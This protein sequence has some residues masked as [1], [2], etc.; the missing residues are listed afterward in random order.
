[1]NA[2]VSTLKWNNTDQKACYNVS[3]IV[4]WN[5]VTIKGYDFTNM[6]LNLKINEDILTGIIIFL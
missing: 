6:C 2:H 4:D 5:F 1:M 3:Y